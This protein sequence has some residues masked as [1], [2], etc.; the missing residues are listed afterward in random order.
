VVG[1]TPNLVA[2]LQALAG[3]GAVV[4]SVSTRR[5]TGRLFEYRDLGATPLKGFA[6][7]VPAFQVLSLSTAGSRFEA[8]RTPTTPL[9]GSDE[10][11]ELLLRRWER[12]K[13]GEG[14]VA[15]ISGEPGIGKSRIAHAI[16]EG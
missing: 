3:P 6:E 10:E 2:R 4:I 9:V 16:L 7:N 11:I 13:R 8:L 1:E 5:L 12:A 14:C 15:L